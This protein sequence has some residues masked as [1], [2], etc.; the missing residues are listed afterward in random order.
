M[1]YLFIRSDRDVFIRIGRLARE[2]SEA[3]STISML[4]DQYGTDD[5]CGEETV[6]IFAKRMNSKV[7][8]NS[9][10]NL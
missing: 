3:Y 8:S 1:I 2:F 5:D 6:M 10:M 7:L 4:R 9:G